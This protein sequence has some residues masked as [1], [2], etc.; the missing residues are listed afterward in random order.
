MPEV[1]GFIDTL[2]GRMLHP[3][4]FVNCEHAAETNAVSS[5]T[6]LVGLVLKLC[7]FGLSQ[8]GNTQV[9]YDRRPG[10]KFTH[11]MHLSPHSIMKSVSGRSV[12]PE[13]LQASVNTSF[14]K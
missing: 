9:R 10:R 1:N 14:S 2:P 6:I 3:V 8:T 7:C 5:D 4:E 13:S 11:P 12:P